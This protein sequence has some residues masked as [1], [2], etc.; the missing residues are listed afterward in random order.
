MAGLTARIAILSVFRG[1]LQ[2]L[3]RALLPVGQWPALMYNKSMNGRAAQLMQVSGLPRWIWLSV[4]Y[5]SLGLAAAGAVLPIVPT[6]PFLLVALWAGT[7][8]SPRLRFRLYRHPRYGPIL[9][10]WHRHGVVPASAKLLACSLMLASAIMLWFSQVPTALFVFMCVFFTAVA[11]FIL[12]RP[13]RVADPLE[14][15]ES[16]RPTF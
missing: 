1:R 3:V 13:S 8:A 5:C 7:R 9:R 2:A 12:S 4:T 6:T 15:P 14:Q 11:T 10:N 16:C